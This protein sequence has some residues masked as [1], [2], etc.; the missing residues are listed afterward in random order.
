MKKTKILGDTINCVGCGREAVF[1]AGHVVD[2][3]GDHWLAGWCDR[4]KCVQKG[5]QGH[6]KKFMGKELVYEGDE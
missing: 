2:K 6:Y 1:W 5:F 4:E 3:N